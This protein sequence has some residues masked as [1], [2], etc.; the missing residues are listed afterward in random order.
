MRQAVNSRDISV[1][2]VSDFRGRE[3][4]IKEET[5]FGFPGNR[6]LRRIFGRKTEEVAESREDYIT[7]NFRI[8]TL[9]K[10]Y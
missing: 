3:R 1:M 2:P 10:C 7:R 9:T 6:A 4:Q 5:G 8:Y